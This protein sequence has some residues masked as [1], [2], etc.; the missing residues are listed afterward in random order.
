MGIRGTERERLH[1]GEAV[2]MFCW[3]T[4]PNKDCLSGKM[5]CACRHEHQ[6]SISFLITRG[7]YSTPVVCRLGFQRNGDEFMSSVTI[8]HSAIL[9]P[10]QANNM[11]RLGWYFLRTG[12][13]LVVQ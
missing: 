2:T 8:H 7:Y 4:S 5:K 10:M 13:A 11:H 12:G 1:S 6:N 3:V 9:P